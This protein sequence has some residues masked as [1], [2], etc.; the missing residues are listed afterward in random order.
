MDTDRD[1]KIKFYH[2]FGEVRCLRC[3]H[4]I[5]E[6]HRTL[7]LS[8][9]HI[10][11]NECFRKGQSHF[12]CFFMPMNPINLLYY[13]I[14][15]S[16]ECKPSTEDRRVFSC[17]QC[18]KPHKVTVFSENVRLISQKQF[19]IILCMFFRLSLCLIKIVIFSV[20]NE[21]SRKFQANKIATKFQTA[22]CSSVKHTPRK[23]RTIGKI[24][25]RKFNANLSM[26]LKT[27]RN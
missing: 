11:C 4:G 19:R 22:N 13:S 25:P 26:R 20:V 6:N 10:F 8:C 16:I 7:L 3:G 17:G 18:R 5:S 12:Y 2:E 23:T 21:R 9:R 1:R 27:N 15:L 24:K 14:C